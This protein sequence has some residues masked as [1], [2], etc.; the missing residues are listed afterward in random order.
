MS[1]SEGMSRLPAGVVTA[2]AAVLLPRVS[3]LY[4]RGEYKKEH[5]LVRGSVQ[6]TLAIALPCAFGLSAI[7][8][9]MVPWYY[10]KEFLV[11]GAMIHAMAFLILLVAWGEVLQSQYLVPTHRD[12]VL[13]E[14]AVLGIAVS[15]GS[16]LLLI[17]LYGVQGAGYAILVTEGSMAAYKTWKSRRGISLGQ[18]LKEAAP[19]I[20]AAV[21]MYAAVRLAGTPLAAAPMT[22]LKQILTGGAVYVGVVGAGLFARDRLLKRR[23][24]G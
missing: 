14:S 23:I 11:C 4:A 22:T 5:P 18:S 20:A 6:A 24:L 8:E 17:R 15:I 7:A 19:F 3:N 21:A 13:L 9:K 10:G 1:N 12:R 2:L 16:N